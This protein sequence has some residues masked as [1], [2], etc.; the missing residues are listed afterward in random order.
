MLAAHVARSGMDAVFVVSP[1]N[2]H[3]AYLVSPWGCYENCADSLFLH[4]VVTDERVLLTA[5]ATT[6]LV[7][8]PDGARLLC[9]DP[10]EAFV[11]TIGT[12]ERQSV[13]LPDVPAPDPWPAFVMA[14]W[15]RAGAR[16]AYRGG[17]DWAFV[18]DVARGVRTDLAL[19]LRPTEL[20]V[21]ANAWSPDGSR[22]AWWGS[23]C[24]GRCV[25]LHGAFAN[26]GG[27]EILASAGDG[28]DAEPWGRI[29][30]KAAFSPDGRAIA[31]VLSGR[32]YVKE[33]R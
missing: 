25:Q 32:L 11:L 31:F 4:N 15:D 12:G 26:G 17:P 3:V 18:Y 19:S 7:F 1:D 30:G 5:T 16:V 9:A 29:G 20:V 22:I 6:P 8:S 23:M 2:V 21:P 33:V 24:L 13:T 27:D 10:G 28:P 14:R